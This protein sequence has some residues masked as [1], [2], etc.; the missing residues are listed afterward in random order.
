MIYYGGCE[1]RWS[2]FT[3][4]K[5]S[6]SGIKTRTFPKAPTACIKAN[7][8]DSVVQPFFDMIYY[9]D[10]ATSQDRPYILF[11]DKNLNHVATFDK[12][13]PNYPPVR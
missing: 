12:Q 6:L 3:L 4:T 9:I 5:N 10:Y 8:D 1:V 11:Y 2:P 13:P 7:L